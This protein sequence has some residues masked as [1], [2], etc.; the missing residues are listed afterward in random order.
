ME[1]SS[2]IDN[3]YVQACILYVHGDD[4]KVMLLIPKQESDLLL[5]LLLDTFDLILHSLYMNV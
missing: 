2:N 4:K 3:T 5:L 1:S